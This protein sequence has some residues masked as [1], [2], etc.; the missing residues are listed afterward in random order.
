VLVVD[1]TDNT[2]NTDPLS[3]AL[4]SKGRTAVANDDNDTLEW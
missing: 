3:E 1:N 4:Q 2:G